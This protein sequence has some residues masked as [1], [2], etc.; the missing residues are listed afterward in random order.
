MAARIP[1]DHRECASRVGPARTC[2][3]VSR[4]QTGL[5]PAHRK[6]TG[7]PHD[8]GVRQ[9]TAA[10]TATAHTEALRAP[11]SIPPVFSITWNFF[12]GGVSLSSA[13]GKAYHAYTFAAEAL[14]Q[15]RRIRVSVFML[16]SCAEL[17]PCRDGAHIL[18]APEACKLYNMSFRRTGLAALL[19]GRT[20]LQSESYDMGSCKRK[21]WLIFLIR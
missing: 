17:P 10:E 20:S 14:T 19:D 4:T 1:R 5:R 18:R 13:P 2:A 12:P 8:P 21:I 3:Y 7:L 11:R 15:E 16:Y 9:P 6:N